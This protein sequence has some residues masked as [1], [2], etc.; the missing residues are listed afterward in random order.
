MPTTSG[1]RLGRYTLK[2][3]LGA[4]GMAEVW[5]AFDEL[6]HRSVAV[7]VIRESISSSSDFTERF[8]REARLAAGLEHPSILPVYDF[9]QEG[10]T[11][12]L[13]M[14]LL[15]GGSLKDRIQGPM[16]PE[17]AIDA[18]TAIASALDH[19]HGKGI[20]HRDVK[21]SNVL[22]DKSGGLLLADFGLAKSAS[23]AS[24]LTQTGMILGT[25][26]YMSPE[27]AMGEDLDA[28]SD[29]YALAVVA[30][31]LLT[32]FVPFKA[33]SP[34]SILHKHLQEPPPPP[35]TKNASLPAAVDAVF[36]SALAKKPED[37]YTSCSE[38]VA[39]LAQAL[40][41][42]VPKKRTRVTGI[43]APPQLITPEMRETTPTVIQTTQPTRV[44][45]PKRQRLALAGAALAAAVLGG[46]FV[47]LV[48]RR[49]EGA[50]REVAMPTPVATRLTPVPV[51][52]PTPQALAAPTPL[53]A[54][55]TDVEVREFRPRS[56]PTKPPREAPTEAPAGGDDS[57]ERRAAEKTSPGGGSL[58]YSLDEKQT[59]TVERE[60]PFQLEKKI[61]VGVQIGDVTI[62]SVELKESPSSNDYKKAAQKFDATF[63]TRVVFTYSNDDR[64]DYKC[65]YFFSVVDGSGKVLGSGDERRSQNK[66]QR[67]DTNRASLKM[68]TADYKEAR[69]IRLKFEIRK[70]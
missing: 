36:A 67:H 64:R 8:V 33:D 9:G 25:P 54:R 18:L 35:T 19:A 56:S 45:S 59:R 15:P 46:F 38:F 3:K 62:E 41:L 28:R 60:V 24:G 70:D 26:L 11:A 12:F 66:D 65:H 69:A 49:P 22:L 17:L 43:T 50:S 1:T 61:P 21:P 4:G 20:L 34:L 2:R 14:Q 5:E 53:T 48:T 31:Q 6:L 57:S 29:Q 27:Q 23:V 55:S 52:E 13:V 68:R 7:K 39:A 10:E 30:F 16:P 37:R 51:E 42:D 63:S 32:G 40:G 47:W 44:E 58:R